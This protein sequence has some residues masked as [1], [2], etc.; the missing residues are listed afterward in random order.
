[1]LLFSKTN[2]ICVHCNML[3]PTQYAIIISIKHFSKK[4]EM[5]SEI[6]RTLLNVVENNTTLHYTKAQNSLRCLTKQVVRCYYSTVDVIVLI[7][8]ALFRNV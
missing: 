2:K 8:D 4:K 6:S 5:L 1:M 7:R 3:Y